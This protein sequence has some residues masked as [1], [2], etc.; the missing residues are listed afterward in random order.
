MVIL[1]MVFFTFVIRRRIANH[2][3]Q[4][5]EVASSKT[6]FR[7]ASYPRRVPVTFLLPLSDSF[8]FLSFED[9]DE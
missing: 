3:L 4:A 8:S 5:S 9:E 2:N 1:R 7:N 6:T